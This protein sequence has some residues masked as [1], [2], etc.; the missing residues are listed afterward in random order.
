[1]VEAIR[2]LLLAWRAYRI[3][4]EHGTAYSAVLYRDVPRVAIFVGVGRESWR[5]SQRAIE[6]LKR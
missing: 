5:I 3:A 6:E 4:K 2:F 1:M